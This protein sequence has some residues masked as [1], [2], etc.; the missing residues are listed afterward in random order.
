MSTDV[1]GMIECRP[2]ARLWSPDDE[3]SVW[4]VAIGLFLLNRGNAYD[5]LACLFGIRDSYGFRPLAEDRGFPVD[6]PR[7][8][9]E[10][11]SPAT[12]VPTMFTGLPG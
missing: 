12:A 5:G 4:K 3:D 2:G 1:S 10:L 9:C 8:G 11:S 7:M 6:A